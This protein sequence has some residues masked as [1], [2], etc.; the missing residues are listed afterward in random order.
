[1][2]ELVEKERKAAEAAKAEL[3]QLRTTYEV[4]RVKTSLDRALE[5]D[6]V[7]NQYTRNGIIGEYLAM[8]E[9]PEVDDFLSGLRERT[10]DIF[11]PAHTA[12]TKNKA[13]GSVVQRG[14]IDDAKADEMLKSDDPEVRKQ[15]KDYYRSKYGLA[16]G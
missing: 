13:V 11:G 8:D 10:P 3:E 14:Q 15:G 4:D 9:R 7:A 2:Q 6:G 12:G 1:L 16:A 5:R